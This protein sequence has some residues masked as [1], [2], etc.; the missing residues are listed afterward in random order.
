MQNCIYQ[1]TSFIVFKVISGI[2]SA[3]AQFKVLR[4]IAE[5]KFLG[6]FVHFEI[7][8]ALEE[9]E[10][11]RALVEF[12]VLGVFVSDLGFKSFESC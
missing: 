9:V 3:L 11:A 5:S 1:I 6:G 8:G 12:K 2:L 10:I 4:A 7:L